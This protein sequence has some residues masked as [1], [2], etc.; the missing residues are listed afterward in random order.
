MGKVEV[1]RRVMLLLGPLSGPAAAAVLP[2]FA[3]RAAVDRSRARAVQAC[4]LGIGVA[5]QLAF[6]YSAVP[7]RSYSMEP[8]LLLSVIFARHVVVPLLGR[9]GASDFVANLHETV[10]GGHVSLW[11]PLIVPSVYSVSSL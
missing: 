6:F 2:L 10:A 4:I 9:S 8:S 5:V 11:P 1:F 7:V 3:L